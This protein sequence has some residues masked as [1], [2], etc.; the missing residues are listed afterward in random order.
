[1]SKI[2]TGFDEDGLLAFMSV[3][4]S[5]GNV[6]TFGEPTPNMVTTEFSDTRYELVGFAG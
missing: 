6:Y 2:E 1:V 5:E 3:E 4:V